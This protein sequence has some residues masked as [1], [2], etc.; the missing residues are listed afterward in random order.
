MSTQESI[1]S[2]ELPDALPDDDC[3]GD[4]GIVE[5]LRNL[6][7]HTRHAALDDDEDRY[8]PEDVPL[9]LGKPGAALDDDE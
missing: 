7:G 8:S 2:K 5:R 4:V 9:R 1:G 6:Q 3:L